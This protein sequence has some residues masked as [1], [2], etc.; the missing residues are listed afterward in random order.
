M[1]NA[2]ANNNYKYECNLKN[3]FIRKIIIWINFLQHKFIEIVNK[4][5]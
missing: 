5:S 2:V 3:N 4:V 1:L